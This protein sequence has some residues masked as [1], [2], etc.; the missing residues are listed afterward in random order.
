MVIFLTQFYFSKSHSLSDMSEDSA[1]ERK[2]DF[3][4]RFRAEFTS[5]PFFGP[6]D[7]NGL[8]LDLQKSFCAERSL[9]TISAKLLVWGLM[10]SS[11]VTDLI[12]SSYPAFEL[13]FCLNGPYCMPYSTRQ[14]L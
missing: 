11:L 1:Q 5:L 3:C 13:A 12:D 8:T 10:V 6:E 9:I 2:M 14:P 4:G 7:S